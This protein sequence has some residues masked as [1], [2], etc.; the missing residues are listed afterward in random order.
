[1]GNLRKLEDKK[2]GFYKEKK[3]GFGYGDYGDM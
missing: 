2:K 1:M 3:L